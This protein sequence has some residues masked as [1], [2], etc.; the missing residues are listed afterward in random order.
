MDQEELGVLT[1]ESLSQIFLCLLHEV[2]HCQKRVHVISLEKL[3][4]QSQDLG[5]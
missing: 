2:A 4:R 5:N 1:I 3:I